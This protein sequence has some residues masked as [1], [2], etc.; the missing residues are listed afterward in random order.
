MYLE[1]IPFTLNSSLH[2]IFNTGIEPQKSVPIY[3]R[4][5]ELLSTAGYRSGQLLYLTGVNGSY[6]KRAIRRLVVGYLVPVLYR[7]LVYE[8]AARPHLSTTNSDSNVSIRGDVDL[9]A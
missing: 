5:P 4:R 6:G 1:R 7:L 2:L 8:C 3:A 9:V